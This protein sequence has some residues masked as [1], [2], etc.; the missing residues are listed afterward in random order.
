MLIYIQILTY[1]KGLQ[2]GQI[3]PLAGLFAPGKS[4]IW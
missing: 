3:A 2:N 4:V 1:Y